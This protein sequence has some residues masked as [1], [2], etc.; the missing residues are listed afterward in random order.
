MLG[1]VSS[2]LGE[3][4]QIVAYARLAAIAGRLKLEADLGEPIGGVG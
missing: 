3:F 1:P 4:L 2:M